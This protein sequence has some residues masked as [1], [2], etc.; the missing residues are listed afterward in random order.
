M[1]SPIAHGGQATVHHARELSSGR[2]VAIK[3][4]HPH[5]WADEAF[6]A[7]VRRER[8]SLEALDHPNIVKFIDYIKT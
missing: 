7:R 2:E 6:R 4:F 1:G 5:V 3:V 8:A